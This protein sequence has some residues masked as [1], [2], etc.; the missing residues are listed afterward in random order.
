MS[1]QQGFDDSPVPDYTAKTRLDGRVMIVLGAG[2]YIGRQT[3]HALAQQG[4]KLICVG[5]GE[6]ATG[7]IAQEVGGDALLADA[8]RPDA[9]RELMDEVMRRHGRI[10]GIVDILGEAVRKSFADLTPDDMRRQFELVVEHARLAIQEGAPRIAQ[11][12]GGS[13]TLIGSVAGEVVMQTPE[14]PGYSIAKAALHHM[15]RV[16]AYSYGPS[17]VRINTVAPGLIVTPRYQQFGADWLER[18][19]GQYPLRR[20]GRMEDVAAAVL[21]L[22]SDLGANITGQVLRTDGGLSIQSPAPFAPLQDH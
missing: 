4:A 11:S 16:A 3:A 7:R 8:L 6:A 5:R 12:G 20:T 18:S 19:A 17:G 2:Q 9:M 22:C 13:I 1:V 14:S 10:D 21:F 15:S